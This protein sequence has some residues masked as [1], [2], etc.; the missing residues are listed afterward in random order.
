MQ[1]AH[2]PVFDWQ[3]TRVRHQDAADFRVVRAKPAQ[4]ADFNL[5]VRKFLQQRRFQLFCRALV[6]AVVDVHLRAVPA[7]FHHGAQHVLHRLV[8][9]ARL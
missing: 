5:R 6:H 9:A 1:N 8:V 4:Y 2:A 7:L 3:I